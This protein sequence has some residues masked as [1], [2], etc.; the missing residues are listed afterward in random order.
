[1]ARSAA[2]A[3]RRLVAHEVLGISIIIVAVFAL[4]GIG[5]AAGR[6]SAP[7]LCASAGDPG[8]SGSYSGAADVA[9]D[10]GAPR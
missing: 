4:V 7:Q 9:V 5:F 1:M 6:G 2:Q 3:L 10:A 8:S